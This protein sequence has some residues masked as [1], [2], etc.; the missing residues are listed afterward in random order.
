MAATL[1]QLEQPKSRD[2]SCRF[3]IAPSLLSSAINTGRCGART[4]MRDK[5]IE[6]KTSTIFRL[7]IGAT[8]IALGSACAAGTA[9]TS[10]SIPPP[11][12]TVYALI[13][14]DEFDG[15]PASVPDP[16]RW[17]Y[18]IGAGGWGNNELETYTQD[19]ANAHLIADPGASDG[20]ALAITALHPNNGS[21]TS[22]R[23]V[24]AG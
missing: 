18:N 17:D 19:A 2:T 10:P 11:A 7:L 21:Y 1:M 15:G 13:W 22:A 6:H 5:I 3:S 14:H 20:K 23:L 24:T 16:A 8:G 4:L 12:P 9:G